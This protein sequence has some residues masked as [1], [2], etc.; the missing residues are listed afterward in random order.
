MTKS[1]GTPPRRRFPGLHMSPSQL[2]GI[3]RGLCECTDNV[4]YILDWEG[5]VLDMSHSGEQLLG[6]EVSEVVN[7]PVHELAFESQDIQELLALAQEQDV[8]E[9]EV[10]LRHAQGHTV[11]FLLCISRWSDDAGTSQGLLG[12]A[13]DQSKWHKFQEDLVRIDRL[14][15]MGRM[16][17]AIVHDLKNPLSII[18][19]AAG[20]G[21]VVV[22]D[23]QG[24]AEADRAEL[25]R[26]LR[27]IEEQ[28]SRCR[29]ITNQILDF[30]R[31]TRPERKKFTL[32]SLIQDTLRY[33]EPE[34]KY[35]TEQVTTEMP[36]AMVTVHSDYK[37]LQQVLVN[38]VSN[39]IH[40]VREKSEGKG[41]LHIMLR[42]ERDWGHIRIADN[43]PGIPEDVQE[44]IFELF[45]TTKPEGKGTG[46][47]LPIC[48]RIM[49]RL[50][51]S[52]WFESQVGTGT[53]F[54]L[55]LPKQRPA[56]A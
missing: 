53:T 19:Q 16:A 36:E 46:L 15:E 41:H 42:E 5:R 9:R 24:V 28:T 1:Q 14:T 7:R 8:A 6:W 45:Y 20:W 55:S 51:G 37:L 43:G 40:A 27:E 35:L 2:A 13:S 29:A 50:G 39:A 17:A 33:M 31:D 49:K 38:L 25:D 48:R 23:A 32:Q 10:F 34:L 26:A 11:P 3:L 30:V 44:H 52:I 54:H 21:K 4:L 47:G 56:R 22:E 18:N 12:V